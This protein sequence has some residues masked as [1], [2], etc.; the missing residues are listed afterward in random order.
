MIQEIGQTEREPR[1][2]NLGLDLLEIV[3]DESILNPGL[4]DL[5]KRLS[6]EHGDFRGLNRDAVVETMSEM[7]LG[8]TAEETQKEAVNKLLPYKSNGE[9]RSELLVST[10]ATASGAHSSER[11]HYKDHGSI[12]GMSEAIESRDTK[13]AGSG[14]TVVIHTNSG[15]LVSEE[16]GDI[17]VINLKDAVVIPENDGSKEMYGEEIY[18]KGDALALLMVCNPDSEILEQLRKTLKKRNPVIKPYNLDPVLQVSLLKLMRDAEIDTLDVNSNSPEVATVLTD[19]SARY[20]NVM[21]AANLRIDNEI[22]D[23][24]EIAKHT[25]KM[26]WKLSVLAKETGYHPDEIPGYWIEAGEDVEKQLWLALALHSS[27]YGFADVYRKPAKGTDGGGQAVIHIGNLDNDP[28][29]EI[30]KKLE[31]GQYEEAVDILKNNLS[32]DSNAVEQIQRMTT[33]SNNEDVNWVVEANVEIFQFNYEVDQAGEPIRFLIET[34]PAVYLLNGEVSENLSVQLNDGNKEWG[35]NYICTQNNWRR[36]IQLA[37]DSG[38]ID[39]EEGEFLLSVHSKLREKM[40]TYVESVNSSNR[41]K[42]G[43]VRGSYDGIV[44]KLAGDFSGMMVVGMG[45]PNLRANGTESAAG[46]HEQS[47][48]EYGEKGSSITRNFSPNHDYGTTKEGIKAACKQI[49]KKCGIEID[50]DRV[51]LVGIS[52]GWGQIG[53]IGENGLSLISEALIVEREMRLNGLIK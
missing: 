32:E 53:L 4:E 16:K 22:Q 34:L 3:E 25:Q 24:L 12:I 50:E 31:E 49:K 18:Q 9:V 19:K 21:E 2:Q 43:L 42:N 13:V 1:P 48:T 47:K 40:K 11:E 23:P 41:F 51:G 14:D 46:L 38:E 39:Q 20:P 30:Q 45:D 26:E 7:L 44:G 37:Q 15:H 29:L 5:R 17:T 28:R 33:L 36:L 27:R 8:Q 52:E 6:K 10:A 35:G